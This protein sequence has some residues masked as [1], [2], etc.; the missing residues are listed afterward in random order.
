MQ[1][2]TDSEPPCTPEEAVLLEK[3]G[4]KIGEKINFGSFSKVYKAKFQ[5][6]DVAA[7][8]I[9]LR[10]TSKEYRQKFLPRELN[11]LQRLRHPNVITIHKIIT[12]NHKIYI[13]MELAEGGDILE[14]LRANGPIPESQAKIWFRQS[15]EALRWDRDR[16]W[17]QESAIILPQARQESA[18][19]FLHTVLCCSLIF[20]DTFTITE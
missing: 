2:A 6:K 4:F 8:V 5:G 20:T 14:H 18:T 17:C 10:K 19:I 3:K 1:D 11:T 13:F 16:C 15:A 12:M 9:D 7:K